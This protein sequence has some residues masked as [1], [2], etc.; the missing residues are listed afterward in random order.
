M[1]LVAVSGSLRAASFNTAILRTAQDLALPGVSIEIFGLHDLPLFNEDVEAE[2]DPPAVTA[3]KAAVRSADGLLFACP[4]Y[5]G[6]IT[7]VLKNAIDWASRPEGDQPAPLKDQIAC[8]VG[9]SPGM[10]GSVRGQDQLRQVLRRA[11]AHVAPIGE[12]LVFQAHTKIADGRLT[13]ERTLAALKR[14]L[15]A[16]VSEVRA[17]TG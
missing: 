4:E 6:G 8:I 17:R 5:N 14:H 9:A 15:E 12:V 2:G 10:T 7:G 1:K 13:D 16:F 11:L 3:W